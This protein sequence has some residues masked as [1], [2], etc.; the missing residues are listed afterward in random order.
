MPVDVECAYEGD[1]LYL[2]QC[3]PASASVR[4]PATNGEPAGEAGQFP[5]AWAQPA[6]AL[7]YWQLED[8]HAP[9]PVLPLDRDF[10]ENASAGWAAASGRS[11]APERTRL[12]LFNTYLYRATEAVVPPSEEAA[13]LATH[14]EATLEMLPRMSTLWR[15]RWLPEIQAHLAYWDEWSL[16]EAATSALVVHLDDTKKRF[17]RIWELHFTIVDMCY[18]AMMWFQ[19]LY[20]ELFGTAGELRAFALLQGL[21]SLTVAM[22]V[23]LSDL[24]RIAAA[25]PVVDEALRTLPVDS[26]LETLASLPAATRFLEQF[27]RYLEEHGKRSSSLDLTS[28]PLIEDPAPLLLQL[29]QLLAAPQRDPRAELAAQALKRQRSI[30]AARDT[31]RSHSKETVERFERYLQAAQDG[32]ILSEDHNYWIDY[33]VSFRVREVLMECGRRLTER[34]VVAERADVCYLRWGEIRSDLASNGA[35]DRA[36]LVT[37][38]KREIDHWSSVVP[39]RWLGTFDQSA[40]LPGETEWLRGSPGSPGKARGVAR[41]MHSIDDAKRL[42]PGDI[43]VAATTAPTWTTF[44]AT[45]AGV[46]T[47]SGGVLSHTAVVACEYRLPAVVGASGATSLISDGQIIEIDGRTGEVRRWSDMERVR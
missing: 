36:A 14:R 41:I 4:N 35:A 37:A 43:L 10:W 31:L 12:E 6:D 42:R 17:A 25:V 2:L 47:D 5:V 32:V 26:V 13:A 22:G 30:A 18:P 38:R 46:V 27:D 21:G 28:T 34:G 7:L 9:S 24:R 16:P 8:L 3:R 44:F 39:P 29:R 19:E 45:I 23:A 1:K 33:G 20:S 40:A 15:T 11:D